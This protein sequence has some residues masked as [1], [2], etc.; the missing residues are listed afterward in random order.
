MAWGAWFGHT[1]RVVEPMSSWPGDA[2]GP[3]VRVAR[4]A[5]GQGAAGCVAASSGGPGML[6][7]GRTR[8]GTRSPPIAARPC[9]GANPER[10]GRGAGLVGRA[11]R[12]ISGHRGPACSGPGR[13]R[14]DWSQRWDLCGAAVGGRGDP[15]GAGCGCGRLGTEP[16][17]KGSFSLESGD[18]ELR[19][20]RRAAASER[21]ELPNIHYGLHWQHPRTD[22]DVRVS[23]KFRTL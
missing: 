22:P 23:V 14:E 19:A 2:S 16:A 3:A 6:D 21:V 1:L 15:A 13:E 7:S 10:R 11:A 20:I 5:L 12:T 8:R 17:E 4:N 18:D 9:K